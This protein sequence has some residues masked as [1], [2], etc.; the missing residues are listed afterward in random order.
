MPPPEDV[1]KPLAP[2]ATENEQIP[3]S[4]A[5]PPAAKLHIWQIQA[6]R[7]AL[8]VAAAVAL[9]WAGYAMRAVTV[10]LLVALLL[11]YLF[12]PLVA[13]LS[14]PP[15]RTAAAAMPRLSRPVVVGGLLV[16]VGLALAIALAIM[17]PLVVGQTISLVENMR[18]GRY[19]NTLTRLEQ[20]APERYR[21]DVQR[22]IRWIQGGSADITG[23]A[24]PRGGDDWRN[25]SAQT[26]P[27]IVPL[28]TGNPAADEQR[29]RQIV[30]DEIDAAMNERQQR[31]GTVR[32]DRSQLNAPLLSVVQ[33]T[34][35][36]V[37][38]VL[39]TI[40]GWGLLAFLIP[41]YF[42]FFSIWFPHVVRFGR[43][44][45][46][47]ANRPRVL[48]LIGKMDRAV[49][50]FVR[51]RIVICLITG[52]LL[53]AGWMTVGVPYAIVL[54]MVTGA[55]FIVPFLSA[56]GIPLAVGLLALEQLGATVAAGGGSAT[57]WSWGIIIKPAVVYIVV[58]AIETYV[59]TPLIAGKATNL[60]PVTILVAVLAG[61]SVG[62][63]YGMILAIPVAACLKILVTDVLLPR[64][65]A[66]TAAPAPPS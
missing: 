38:S 1:R 33:N 37:A 46:P 52:V 12:E 2:T 39:G 23:D 65:R 7:D 28:D 4:S 9:V 56:V 27:S 5:I 22:V 34:A 50:G 64:V 36:V 29:L 14:G 55:F 44:L 15:I 6:V 13:R 26:S 41:F 20:L 53:S 61:G 10:P 16:T 62:G 17:I 60:D 42:F 66:W 59:L 18:Q 30:R 63:V 31:I 58:N 49:A 51:G 25:S 8:L 35:R 45:I 40:I 54:G 19:A 48:E 21:D 47:E 11:A 57:G 43:S 24:S 3:S 32:V